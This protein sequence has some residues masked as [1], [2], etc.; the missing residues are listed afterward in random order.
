MVVDAVVFVVVVVVVVDRSCITN[1]NIAEE[2]FCCCCCF[3]LDSFG[4]FI[5]VAF[6]V[7]CYILLPVIR[8]KVEMKRN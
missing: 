6:R 5:V 8:K 3:A 4:I 7:R 2:G 1:L